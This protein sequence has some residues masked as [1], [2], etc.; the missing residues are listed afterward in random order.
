MPRVLILSRD[1]MFPSNLAGTLALEGIDAEIVAD[2][3]RCGELAAGDLVIVDLTE[4]GADPAALRAAI[5]D[6][7]LTLAYFAHVEPQVREAALASGIERVYPRSR[8]AR[9]GAS[10]VAPLLG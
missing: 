7:V 5:P 4:P 6:G 2:P 9:E 8:V 10:L 3:A 1:L